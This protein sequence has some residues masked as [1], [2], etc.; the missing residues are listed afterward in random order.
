MSYCQAG[1]TQPFVE[2]LRVSETAKLGLDLPHF[3]DQPGE[4]IT[5]MAALFDLNNTSHIRY[6]S[7]RQT[8]AQALT[9]RYF[10]LNVGRSPT[11]KQVGTVTSV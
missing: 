9:W 10:R 2:S 5:Q 4:F 1:S 8:L 6:L 7:D 3:V 11:L